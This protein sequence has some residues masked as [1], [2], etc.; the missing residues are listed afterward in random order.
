MK[1]A[2]VVFS[3]RIPAGSRHRQKGRRGNPGNDRQYGILGAW[4]RH[5]RRSPITKAILRVGEPERAQ[6]GPSW[7]GPRGLGRERIEIGISKRS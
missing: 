5:V 1:T 2:E 6:S 7:A 3:P 4:M